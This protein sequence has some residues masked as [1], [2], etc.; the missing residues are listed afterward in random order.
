MEKIQGNLHW[1]SLDILMLLHSF[2]PVACCLYDKYII[3]SFQ[4]VTTN[5][6]WAANYGYIHWDCPL[7]QMCW[8]RCRTAEARTWRACPLSRLRSSTQVG[9]KPKQTYFAVYFL[10][11]KRLVSHKICCDNIGVQQRWSNIISIRV[12]SNI[13]EHYF[14]TFYIFKILSRVVHL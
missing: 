2:L 5:L 6:I 4:F 11:F 1:Y 14:F 13:D 8:S 9:L 12:V 7:Q 3:A 10:V